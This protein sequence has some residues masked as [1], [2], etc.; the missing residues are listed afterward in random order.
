LIK[1]EAL[2]K[3]YEEVVLRLRTE[4]AKLE[5]ILSEG[6]KNFEKVSFDLIATEAICTTLQESVILLE[7]RLK[8]GR[9]LGLDITHSNRRE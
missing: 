6:K 3:Q 8:E 2:T 4:R 5:T 7:H 9:V 1:Y